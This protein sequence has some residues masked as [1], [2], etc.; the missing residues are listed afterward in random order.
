MVNPDA[1]R[2]EWNAVLQGQG[3]ERQGMC[4]CDERADLLELDR[5]L[6]VRLESLQTM[7]ELDIVVGGS[8]LRLDLHFI[9]FFHSPAS[10]VAIACIIVGCENGFNH[11]CLDLRSVEW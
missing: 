11:S 9:G 2:C 3:I 6:E 10:S 1:D 4:G 5:S 8:F 7:G